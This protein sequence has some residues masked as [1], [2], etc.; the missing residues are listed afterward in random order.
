MSR[1]SRFKIET[2]QVPAT[3]F[4]S[5]K[6]QQETVDE[7]IK[8]LLGN[9][10]GLTRKQ[11]QAIEW[12]LNE[13]TD[14]V[15][16]H[17]ESSVGG[18]VQLSMLQSSTRL[19]ELVVVDAGIGIPNSLRTTRPKLADHEAL[20][21]ALREG[22][23]RDKRIGQGNGL[24]GT[25]QICEKSA[26]RLRIDSGYSTLLFGHEDGLHLRNDSVPYE[27]TTIDLQVGLGTE[28]VLELALIFGGKEHTPSDHIELKYE[29]DDLK[30]V[31]FVLC[32]ETSSFGSR[33]AARP[34]RT[35]LSN[36]ISMCPTERIRVSFRDIRI[37]SSSFADEVFGRLF[38]ELGPLTFMQRLEF[39]SI[40]DTVRV[41]VDR[42][43]SQR[44]VTDLGSRL[45]GKPPGASDF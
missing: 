24:F 31:D 14:N 5:A 36:L 43:I 37:V 35:K 42:A 44:A 12:V 25:F 11:F 15:L 30:Y 6:G 3:Q 34:I 8:T 9:V 16:N 1:A 23:T 10:D 45:S 29:S 33:I 4:T 7:L 38:V 20:E 32:E 39:V 22:V 21:C 2:A 13:V 40:D 27:G 18:L 28:S 17:A 41:L 26:G 19:I